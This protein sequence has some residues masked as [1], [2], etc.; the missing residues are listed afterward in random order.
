[1]DSRAEVLASS[2]TEQTWYMSQGPTVPASTL[3]LMLS[4]LL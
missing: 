2:A 3:R 1:M 4:V